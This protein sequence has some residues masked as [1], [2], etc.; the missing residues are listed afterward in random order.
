MKTTKAI[1][2]ISALL[3][4][5]AAFCA[6]PAWADYYGRQLRPHGHVSNADGG[7]IS[8]LSLTGTFSIGVNSRVRARLGSN[9]SINSVT[10]TKINFSTELQDER[11]EYDAGNSSFT[12]LSNGNYFYS[13]CVSWAANATGVRIL[14]IQVNSSDF[15][16]N[17]IPA[18]TPILSQCISGFVP[19]VA[20]DVVTFTAWQDTGG[21]L[22]LFSGTTNQFVNI[23]RLP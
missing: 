14:G 3:A 10:T 5:V 15:Y 16:I 2:W 20:G 22:L 12:A 18:A 1:R 17:Q 21:A 23:Y 6:A 7:Q 9:Q 11:S 13:A 4:A 8:N 19:L